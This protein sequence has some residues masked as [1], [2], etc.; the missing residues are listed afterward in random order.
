MTFDVIETVHQMTLHEVQ[1]LRAYAM[2]LTG[3]RAAADDLVED[4][5]VEVFNG[6][7]AVIDGDSAMLMALSIIGTT[8]VLDGDWPSTAPSTYAPGSSLFFWRLTVRQRAALFLSEALGLSS[9]QLARACHCPL[10]VTEIHATAAHILLEAS[11]AAIPSFFATNN[12]RRSQQ[13]QRPSEIVP[14]L[15]Q[16]A[17]DPI[18]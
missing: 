2:V 5:L 4:A 8:H 14:R 1:Q 17:A 11:S 18:Q 7:A 10:G 9:Y 15:R 6:N 12:Q 3:S 13:N 16:I